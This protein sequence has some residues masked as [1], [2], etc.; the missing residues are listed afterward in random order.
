MRNLWPDPLSNAQ[1]FFTFLWAS[2]ERFEEIQPTEHI[3]QLRLTHTNELD[4]K[5]LE[6]FYN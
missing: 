3:F 5:L 4:N 6:T 2:V 1:E